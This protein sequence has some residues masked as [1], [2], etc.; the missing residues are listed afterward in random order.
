[1]VVS[2]CLVHRP[3]NVIALLL[4][5]LLL[6]LLLLLMKLVLLLCVLKLM[7]HLRIH[8]LTLTVRLRL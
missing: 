3:L 4:L 1:M 8:S 7:N 2:H 6:L 5:V